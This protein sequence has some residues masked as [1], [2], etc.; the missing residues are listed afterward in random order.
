MAASISYK[1]I[2]IQRSYERKMKAVFLL[3]RRVYVCRILLDIVTQR[4]SLIRRP[5][6]FRRGVRPS[7]S[8][9]KMGLGRGEDE[10][11]E[12]YM[13]V[14][15]WPVA[16]DPPALA[17]LSSMRAVGPHMA[18]ELVYSG[19]AP[20]AGYFQTAGPVSAG[21]WIVVVFES[22]SVVV[23]RIHV[24]T[25]L[26]DGSLALQSG[27]FVELSPRLLRLEPS[28]PNVVC[29]DFVRVG[30][31]PSGE[32]ATELSGLARMVWG[33]PTRCLRLTVASNPPVA[34]QIVFH[35]IAV[36]TRQ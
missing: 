6:V 31:I 11:A 14:K 29:A 26:P 27:A 2:V 10:E 22:D 35:Q 5:P 12:S 17:V 8:G 13:V 23:D 21:D 15:P 9:V 36:F 30:D 16:D 19:A 7:V 33:R 20:G 25:G 24:R 3:K 1:C 18:V 28:V 32:S 34:S 4:V